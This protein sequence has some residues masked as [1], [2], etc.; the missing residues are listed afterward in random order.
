M[1]IGLEDLTEDN[2]GRLDLVLF[3]GVLYHLRHPFLAI[4]RIAKLE[5]ETLVLETHL[6]AFDC[7][8]PAMVFYPTTEL[9]D[10][11]TNWWGPNIPCVEA[12]LRDVGFSDVVFRPHPAHANRGIFHGRR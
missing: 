9:N 11:P 6:D 10:D 12:M 2:V 1:D 7:P 4:E 5:K 3:A 8:R